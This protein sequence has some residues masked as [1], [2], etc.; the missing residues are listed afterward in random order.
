MLFKKR[1]IFIIATFLIIT[2]I[3]VALCVGYL[4]EDKKSEYEGT[5]VE[6]H[7]VEKC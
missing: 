5:L 6:A 3:A 1:R 7:L 4:T 2:A